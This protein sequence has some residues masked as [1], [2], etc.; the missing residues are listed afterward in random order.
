MV[1]EAVM[2][3]PLIRNYLENTGID[4]RTGTSLFLS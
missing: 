1:G 2:K 3:G 4:K